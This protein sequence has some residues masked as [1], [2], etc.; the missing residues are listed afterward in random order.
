VHDMRRGRGSLGLRGVTLAFAVGLTPAVLTPVLAQAQRM[1]CAHVPVV[2]A[3]GAYVFGIEDIALDAAT[4][5]LILSAYDRHAVAAALEQGSALPPG[6]LFWLA[7]EDLRGGPPDMLQ[8]H[9]LR[10][11][12]DTDIQL[13]PHGIDF[14]DD[15]THRRLAVVNRVKRPS[16][17]MGAQVLLFEAAADALVLRA[18][19]SGDAFCRA[20][21]IA[22]VDAATA[23]FTFDQRNCDAWGIW[24]ERVFQQR[25]SG[26]RSVHFGP[27]GRVRTRTHVQD[28]AFA[29]GITLDRAH[30]RVLV[31]NTRGGEVI[32]YD[33]ASFED[34]PIRRHWS[35]AIDGGPDNL[36]LAADGRVIAAV[37][38]SVWALFWHI[39]GW[40]SAPPGSVV[41]VDRAGTVQVLVDAAT[42]GIPA[43]ATAAVMVD[44]RLIVASAWDQGLGICTPVPAEDTR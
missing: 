5:R 37:H 30:G 15:G 31:A 33:L 27:D 17:H 24:K 20:N 22:L 12:A 26:V 40:G 34:G 23:F 8:A 1:H 38:P 9:A 10:V 41:A 18:R 2:T 11:M 44:G 19:A 32:A 7:G 16:G 25:A 14:Y 36:S 28:M 42:L 29:N 39:S 3:D 4:D 13:L 21:D 6:N 43:A 35:A